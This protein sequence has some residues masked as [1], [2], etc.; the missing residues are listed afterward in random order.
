MRG[1][2]AFD[3]EGRVGFGVAQL[4]RLL[5]H[6]GEVEALVAHLGQDEVG[7]AV[8]DAGQPV[9]AVGGQAFAQRLDDRDAAGHRRFER[10]HDALGLRGG[11]DF[12]AVHGQQRL[13]G[14]DHVLAVGDRLQHQRARLVVAADQ[15]D[16]DVDFRIVDD[17]ERVGD[18]LDFAAGALLG[19]LEV[20]GRDGHHFD[21]ASGAAADFFLIAFEDVERSAADIADA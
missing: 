10:D 4:L 2:D 19:A 20:A 18:D 16:D 8:D 5:E 15:F 7:G 6:G 21:A 17:V 13:V 12:V 1:V 11:K 14:G 9:D 3:V